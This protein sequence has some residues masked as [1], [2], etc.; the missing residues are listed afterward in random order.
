MED[1]TVRGGLAVLFLQTIFLYLKKN[2]LL[3]VSFF[4]LTEKYILKTLQ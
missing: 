3:L 4:I 2:R 1:W